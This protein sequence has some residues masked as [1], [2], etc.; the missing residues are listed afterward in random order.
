MIVTYGLIIARGITKIPPWASMFFG[1]ILMIV[2]NVIT[3][4]EALEAINM[5]VIL[6][7]ITLFTFASALEVSGF[8]KFLAYK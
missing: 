1:G 5:D 2:F 8:L 6:F 7:L 3:P 4:I